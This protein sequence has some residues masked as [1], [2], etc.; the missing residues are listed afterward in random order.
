MSNRP[1]NLE[2]NG[3]KTANLNFFDNSKSRHKHCTRSDFDT[4]FQ[5]NPWSH[6]L[7]MSKRPQN[8]EKNGLK[9]ANFYFF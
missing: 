2:K 3:Q 1:E 9:T 8:L 5:D 7:E 4:K 6:P